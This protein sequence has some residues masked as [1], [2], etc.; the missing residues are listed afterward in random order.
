MI[1]TFESSIEKICTVVVVHL[2]R[3]RRE[4]EWRE[5]ITQRGGVWRKGGGGK[6]GEGEE[7]DSNAVEQRLMYLVA[8]SSVRD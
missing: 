8:A 1:T 6:D 5:E 7:N 4:T 3:R 2:E